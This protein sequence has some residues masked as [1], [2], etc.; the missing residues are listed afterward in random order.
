MKTSP[1]G[2]YIECEYCDYRRKL[3]HK[4]RV[5]INMSY[6]NNS[7]HDNRKYKYTDNTGKWDALKEI[8]NG[9]NGFL[10]IFLIFIFLMML[11]IHS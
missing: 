4:D 6:V 3:K 2:G 11:L 10:I 7:Y 8:L 1:G 9:E 5:S